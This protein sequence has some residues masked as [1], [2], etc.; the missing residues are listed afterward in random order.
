MTKVSI[1]ADSQVI[2]LLCSNLAIPK[3]MESEY[4]PLTLTEWNTLAKKISASS[5]KRPEAFLLTGVDEWQRDLG[6][7]PRQLERLEKLL[8]RRGSLA[9]ELKRLDDMGIWVLTRSESTYPCRLKKILKDKAPALLYG[10]GD[11]GLFDIRGVGIVGS[12]D[13]DESAITFTQQLVKACVR[14]RLKVVSGGA[15]GVDSV[16]QET[17]LAEDGKVISILSNGLATAMR[18]K[19]NREAVM[20][21]QLLLVSPFHPQARFN[22]GAAMCRNKLIY[23]LSHFAVVISAT[24]G[25]GGTWSGATENVKHSWVPLFVREAEGIPDGNRALIRNGVFRLTADN[26]NDNESLMRI[27]K[28]RIDE[29]KY[30]RSLAN[31]NEINND[32]KP[33]KP[34]PSVESEINE[35]NVIDDLFEVVWPYIQNALA[36]IQESNS[37]TLAEQFKVNDKQMEAWLQRATDLGKLEKLIQPIRYRFNLDN[38][39][40]EEDNYQPLL[41]FDLDEQKI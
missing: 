23:A 31:N 18:N 7:D 6:L 21:N 36:L 38:N 20:K 19:A 25:K 10:C 13:A 15:R 35:N 17:A 8:S 3:G 34:G 33:L 22:V 16:A 5:L 11:M 12:R 1:S 24:E 40:K 9:I 14:D 4:K 37:Q 39:S 41:L 2:L 26:L 28:T 30:S 27:L 29:A 32:K